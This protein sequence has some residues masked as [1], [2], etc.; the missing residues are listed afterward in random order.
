MIWSRYKLLSHTGR[1]AENGQVQ[2]GKT[3]I[4]IEMISQKKKKKKGQ[5]TSHFRDKK[6]KPSILRRDIYVLW[7]QH[8]SST[9]T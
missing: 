6:K 4:T 3:M 8:N 5:K 9:G 1:L 2:T 7:G